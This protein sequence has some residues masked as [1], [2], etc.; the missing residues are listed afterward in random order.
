MPDITGTTAL[1]VAIGLAFLFFLLS[2]VVSAVNELIASLLA[3]RAKNLEEGIRNLLGDE[4]A[5]FYATPRVKALGKEKRGKPGERRKPSYIPARTFALTVLDTFAPEIAQKM[6]AEDPSQPASRD[7][8][9]VA[10]R[11]IERITYEPVKA[12]LQSALGEARTRLDAFRVALEAEFDAT[13]DRASGWYKRKVQYALIALAIATAFAFNADAFQIGSQ[14]AKDDAVRAAIVAEA[15]ATAEAVAGTGE[16]EPT[17]GEPPPDTESRFEAVADSVDDVKGLGLAIGWNE[18]TI[19]EVSGF[20]DGVLGWLGKLGG[21]LFTGFAVSLGAPFWFD[22][23]GKI[24]HLRSTGNRE[25][26][27]KDDTRSAV[28]RDER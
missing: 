5:A 6:D 9:E 27:A 25:G 12:I 8:I 26:T 22:A 7:V 10:E 1:D 3:W 17:D 18:A 23:L 20:W 21:L 24:S 2:L 11:E 28:D 13:M 14:L 15:T 19:P 16:P 4:T